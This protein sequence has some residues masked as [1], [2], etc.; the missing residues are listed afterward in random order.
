MKPKEREK[1]KRIR[2][3]PYNGPSNTHNDVVLFLNTLYF[4]LNK[5]KRDGRHDIESVLSW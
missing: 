4:G 3:E 5:K 1:E 2:I